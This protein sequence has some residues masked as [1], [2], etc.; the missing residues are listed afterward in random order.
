MFSMTKIGDFF[1]FC[2][3]Y[4][5]HILNILKNLPCSINTVKL[6][7]ARLWESSANWYTTL[8]DPTGKFDPVLWLLY[9]RNT[10]PKLSVAIGSFQ[11]TTVCWLPKSTEARMSPGH[12][13]IIGGSESSVKSLMINTY[14]GTVILSN[15]CYFILLAKSNVLYFEFWINI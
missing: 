14:I 11:V 5:Y 3:Y 13:E 7:L 15:L 1:L 4:S 6:Q 9:I 10:R 12:P 2:Y 8:V